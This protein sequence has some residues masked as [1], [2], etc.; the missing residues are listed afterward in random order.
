MAGAAHESLTRSVTLFGLE[1][2]VFPTPEKMEGTLSL[3]RALEAI[4]S[5]QIS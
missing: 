5:P 2:I 1:S 3:H 4:I